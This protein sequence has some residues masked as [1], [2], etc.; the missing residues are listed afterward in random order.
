MYV[1]TGKPSVEF[2]HWFSSLASPR[3]PAEVLGVQ[4]SH[5]PLLHTPQ[6]KRSPSLLR[7]SSSCEFVEP[8]LEVSPHDPKEN[9]KA[10]CWHHKVLNRFKWGTD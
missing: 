4:L 9:A 8:S 3:P 7:A 5:F 10:D 6:A 1:C 2:E